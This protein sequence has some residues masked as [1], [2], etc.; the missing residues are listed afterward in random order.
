M[1]G[2]K[3]TKKIGKNAENGH[4]VKF[5]SPI[6]NEW[7]EKKKNLCLQTLTTQ[8]TSARRTRTGK[9]LT[10]GHHSHCSTDEFIFLSGDVK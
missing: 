9:L 4:T 5:K 3:C 7:T 8:S 6:R 1:F 2:N 10:E